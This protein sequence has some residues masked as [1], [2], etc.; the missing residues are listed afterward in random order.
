MGN[1]AFCIST[2]VVWEVMDPPEGGWATGLSGRVGI[3]RF[4]NPL[5]QD[6]GYIHRSLNPYKCKDPVAK[7]SPP[8]TLYELF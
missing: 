3:L 1:G 6:A 2:K 4:G 8:G 5:P 7:L